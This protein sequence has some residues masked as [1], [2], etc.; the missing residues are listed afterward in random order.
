MAPEY[1]GRGSALR[2]CSA[3]RLER[4]LRTTTGLRTSRR[5]PPRCIL[6]QSKASQKSD[7]IATG[8]ATLGQRFQFLHVASPQNHVI[9]MK[10]G[11]EAAD[12]VRDLFAPFL[13]AE[14]L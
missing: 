4:A 3:G 5:R 7:R 6:P 1:S 11:D 13:L 10:G 12:P 9:E 2:L 8:A 14:P